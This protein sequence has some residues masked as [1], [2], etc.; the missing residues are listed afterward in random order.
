MLVRI[1][2][3]QKLSDGGD[4]EE[5]VEASLLGRVIHIINCERVW[6]GQIKCANVPSDAGKKKCKFYNLETINR[7]K[8]NLS[9]LRNQNISSIPGRGLGSEH[10]VQIL[11]YT[12]RPTSKWD[13]SQ[14]TRLVFHWTE[15]N[16]ARLR[17]ESVKDV[18]DE[19]KLAGVE[20][21]HRCVGQELSALEHR[22]QIS[23]DDFTQKIR[24]FP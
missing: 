17:T 2:S 10:M 14:E 20:L 3:G 18:S 19:H 22:L 11:S 21:D 7:V 4:L 9:E 6:G 8:G 5:P 1:Q 23:G 24:E 12:R 15:R 16:E 13:Y